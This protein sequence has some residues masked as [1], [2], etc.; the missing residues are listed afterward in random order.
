MAKEK[1]LEGH[2]GKHLCYRAEILNQAGCHAALRRL[3]QPRCFPGGV[4]EAGPRRL[5]FFSFFFFLA[6]VAAFCCS[7]QPYCG[8]SCR[9]RRSSLVPQLAASCASSP[10]C[11]HGDFQKPFS[12]P[13]P[14]SSPVPAPG[15][16]CLLFLAPAPPGGCQPSAGRSPWDFLQVIASAGQRSSCRMHRGF[17]SCNITHL[18]L[19]EK[20]KSFIFPFFLCY[21]LVVRGYGAGRGG[22]LA[23]ACLN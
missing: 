13:Q 8:R 23:T 10:L 22:S 18:H 19:Q 16:Y 11:C 6:A 3:F 14:F 4:A 5:G 21:K 17:I 12:P 15:F 1:L 2:S 9:L 7:P 20:E